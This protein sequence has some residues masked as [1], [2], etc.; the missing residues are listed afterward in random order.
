LSAG[1]HVATV[2]RM[3][4]TRIVL[5]C[6]LKGAFL[7]GGGDGAMLAENV[8]YLWRTLILLLIVADGTVR[9]GPTL[10]RRA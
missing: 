3:L 5:R 9:L 10:G 6:M 1:R 4:V 8:G 2:A 7:A